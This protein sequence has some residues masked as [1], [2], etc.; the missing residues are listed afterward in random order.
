MVQ[1][2]PPARTFGSELGRSLGGNIARGFSEGK[3]NKRQMA[4]LE[5][6][7]ESLKKQGIDLSGI[8]DPKMRQLYV[9]SA[10]Q[11]ANAQELEMIKQAGKRERSEEAQ[12]FVSGIYGEGPKQGLVGAQLASEGKRENLPA[13]ELTNEMNQ[14]IVAEKRPERRKFAD[15]DIAKA[16]AMDPNVGK[17]MQSQNDITIRE[18]REDR[19]AEEKLEAEERKNRTKKEQQF[20]KFNE[21]KLAEV[22]G[23]ERKINVDNARFSR[24]EDLFSD[25]SK[26]PSPLLSALVTKDGAI[27]DIAYSQLTPEA[28]EAVKLIID[29]TSGIKDTYGARVTNFDLQ[30]YLRKLPSLMTSPEGRRRVIRD[31]KSLNDINQTYNEG[32]QDIFEKAGGSDKIAFSEAERRF[33]KEYGSELQRKIDKFI[34]PEKGIFEKMP[35]AKQYLGKKLKDSETGEIFISDGIEWKPFKGE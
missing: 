34:T 26:F 33:K 5:K 29:S 22:A 25:D 10:L 23:I 15:V 32:I 9:S 4:S 21:P 6:E 14:E 31:L 11:G 8:I 12:K 16:M 27:N 1:V 30:T 19:K 20:F 17:A 7:N 18:E 2:L 3:E 28:Q 35:S 24:L 13:E